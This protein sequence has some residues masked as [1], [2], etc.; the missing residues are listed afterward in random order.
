MSF[1]WSRR[2][3]FWNFVALIF[4][5]L[6]FSYSFAWMANIASLQIFGKEEIIIQVN[7]VREMYGAPPLKENFSLNEAAQLKL[8]DMLKGQYFAHIDSQ[9]RKPWDWIKATGYPYYYAG[10]NLAMGFLSSKSIVESWID[11]PSHQ[12]NLISRYFTETGVA[13]GKG[14][15]NGTE[16]IIV[17]Q[18]FASPQ[19]TA[20]LAQAKPTPPPPAVKTPAPSLNPTTEPAPIET[21]EPKVQSEQVQPVELVGKGPVAL[22]LPKPGFFANVLSVVDKTFS[23]YAFLIVLSSLAIIAIDRN[24]R[25]REHLPKFAL[26]GLLLVLAVVWPAFPGMH[27]AFIL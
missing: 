7:Q 25:K 3:I 13:V 12:Q 10:E 17:V 24:Q 1:I 9:G 14:S 27:I 22:V 20:A 15:I 19:K 16:G 8:N 18:I 23:V 4:L 5:K 21:A 11:S 26:H 2:F 6:I